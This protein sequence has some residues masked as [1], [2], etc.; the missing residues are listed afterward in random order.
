M[1]YSLL[2]K[3]DVVRKIVSGELL[4]KEAMVEYNIKSERTIIRWLDEYQRKQQR[5]KEK[6]MSSTKDSIIYAE[7]SC[8]VLPSKLLEN[9][10]LIR[11]VEKEK[12]LFFYLEEYEKAPRGFEKDLLIPKGFLDSIIIQDFPIRGQKSFLCLKRRKW[13]IDGLDKMVYSKWDDFTTLVRVTNE[14]GEYMKSG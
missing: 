14:F 6:E 4:L 5:E 12:A 7:L 8:R 1:K 3:Q 11:I 9:F 2:N 10:E 13:I